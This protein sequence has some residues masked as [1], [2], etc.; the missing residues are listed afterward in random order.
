MENITPQF[1]FE[2]DLDFLMSL[3]ADGKI[4]PEQYQ[5]AVEQLVAQ[6]YWVIQDSK[7]KD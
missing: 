6:W 4:T 2:S 3:L 1:A 7:K 5:Q